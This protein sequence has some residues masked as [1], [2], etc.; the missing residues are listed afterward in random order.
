VAISLPNLFDT[1]FQIFHSIG[2]I[3]FA[4]SYVRLPKEK[5]IIFGHGLQVILTYATHQVRILYKQGAKEP[6]LDYN[7]FISFHQINQYGP[8]AII[9]LWTLILTPYIK[10]GGRLITFFI[11]LPNMV[12]KLDYWERDSKSLYTPS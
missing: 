5:L 8:L 7:P 12:T 2:P 1:N 11:T 10:S 3:I 6:L 4:R 9:K